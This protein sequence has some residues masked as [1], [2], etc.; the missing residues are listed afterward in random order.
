MEPWPG[1]A[2]VDT[3]R[4]RLRAHLEQSPACDAAAV[5]RS[6]QGSGLHEELVVLHAKV[7]GRGAGWV[8]WGAGGWG[9]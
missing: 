2:P 1:A 3:M 6:L 5:L 7:G 4:L 9:G 8:S